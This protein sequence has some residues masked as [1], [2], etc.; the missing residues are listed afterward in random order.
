MNPVGQ[1][2]ASFFLRK[3]FTLADCHHFVSVIMKKNGKASNLHF[4]VVDDDPLSLNILCQY[5]KNKNITFDVARNGMEAFEKVK[6]D[7]GRYDGVLIDCEMPVMNGIEASEKIKMFLKQEN[8]KDLPI[9]ELT[10]HADSENDTRLKRAGM[11]KIFH[12]PVN[13]VELIAFFWE[14]HQNNMECLLDLAEGPF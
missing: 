7:S 13:F 10:G 4:L 14:S 5:L 2:N 12:K 1:V 3:P 11:C 9:Y 6:A 8:K